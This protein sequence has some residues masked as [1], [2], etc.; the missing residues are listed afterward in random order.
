MDQLSYIVNWIAKDVFGVPA[1]LVG[2]MTAIALIASRKSLGDI[3]GGALK[4]TLGFIILGIGAG[5]VIGALN[6]LGALITGSFGVEGVVPTNEAIT[7]IVS[8]I[9]DV[10]QNVALAMFV[11][12]LLSLLIARLTPL[13]YVFLTGHH[14]LFMATV[15]TVVLYNAKVDTA[16]LIGV[17]ALGLATMMVIMPAFAHP[18]MKKVTGNEAVAIGH[19]GTF[20]YIAAGFAGQLVGHGSKSTE[21][22]EFPQSLRFLRDPMV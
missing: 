18:W 10:A 5:A 11:G 1:Y 16:L 22:M 3:V 9:P 8:N 4:A 20:G 14:M 17:A 2:L 7:G 13:R 19:F 21:E 15:L 6:P 12:V